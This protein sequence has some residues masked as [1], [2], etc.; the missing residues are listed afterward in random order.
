MGESVQLHRRAVQHV[1][2]VDDGGASHGVADL[3]QVNVSEL[4]PFGCDDDPPLPGSMDSRLRGAFMALRVEV[5]GV[6]SSGV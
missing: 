1:P 3:E 2:G 5:W 4:G 6:V